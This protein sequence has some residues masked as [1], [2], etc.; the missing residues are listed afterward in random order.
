M[1]IAALIAAL[2]TYTCSVL[3]QQNRW[4]QCGGQGWT[5][6]TNCITPGWT[7]QVQNPCESTPPI[8]ARLHRLTSAFTDYSQCLDGG[9]GGGGGDGGDKSAQASGAGGGGSQAASPA[10]IPSPSQSAAGDN[11][12]RTAD[13]SSFL[14]QNTT[15]GAG[16]SG[17]AGAGTQ[18]KSAQAVDTSGSGSGSGT[19]TTGDDETEESDECETEDASPSGAAPASASSSVQPGGVH[20]PTNY[21]SFLQTG[22]TSTAANGAGGGTTLG[23][24]GATEGGIQQVG[25][26][27]TNETGAA[28][29]GEAA[30]GGSFQF[31]QS[32][33]IVP[34]TATGADGGK[35]PLPLKAPNLATT[36]AYGPATADSGSACGCKGVWQNGATG[37]TTA[38]PSAAV[39]GQDYKG[40]GCG[41][42]FKLTN[43]GLPPATRIPA[44]S[45]PATR[46]RRWWLW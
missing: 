38:A 39:Y 15:G 1:K 3:A 4:D 7:C 45:K 43:T 22:G 21:K 36:T 40:E 31:L 44:E 30:G 17:G 13:F 35:Y 27:T 26:G 32:K 24:S 9:S 19:T 12:G 42:C 20:N 10:A 14:A 23:T 6:G 28:L 18:E 37:F 5:G 25:A 33:E 34:Y 11:T 16:G 8:F 29:A 41:T 46:A 2:L